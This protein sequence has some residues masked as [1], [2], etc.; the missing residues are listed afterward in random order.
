MG[1]VQLAFPPGVLTAAQSA[2]GLSRNPYAAAMQMPAT[3]RAQLAQGRPLDEAPL[4]YE[5]KAARQ[6]LSARPLATPRGAQLAAQA[7]AG[8]GPAPG[9]APEEAA[10]S[11]YIPPLWGPLGA[12]PG[13]RSGDSTLN[14]ASAGILTFGSFRAL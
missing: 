6:P 4:P 1:G 9:A 11:P 10:G 12:C 8:P 14:N 3:A 5:A 7:A 2:R 13:L